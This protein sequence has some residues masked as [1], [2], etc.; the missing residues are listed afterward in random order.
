MRQL[1]SRPFL[2]QGRETQTFLRGTRPYD[3][4]LTN[5]PATTL[6]EVCRTYEAQFSAFNAETSPD[7]LTMIDNAQS[8]GAK[9][10]EA[11]K[12]LKKS[13]KT[14]VNSFEDFAMN[15]WTML[16][17]LQDFETVC[18]AEYFGKSYRPLLNHTKREEF[19]NPFDVLLT[20]ADHEMQDV[21]A[22]LEAIGTRASIKAVREKL[23][24]KLD[25][26]QKSIAKLQAGKKTFK[27]FFTSKPSTQVVAE[28]EAEAKQ[29][30]EEIYKVE[31]LLRIITVRMG[32]AEIPDYNDRRLRKYQHMIRFFARSG[33]QE[34]NEISRVARGI[35]LSEDCQ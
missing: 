35:Y 13:I 27:S 1:L 33:V 21:E 29:T 23:H 8:F 12:K 26:H 28:I 25:S 2:Y 9:H 11:L 34:F 18:V 5:M 7:L 16:D 14:V 22:L 30:E 15:Y 3:I 19:I 10:I 32:K 24:S 6:A 20:G 4:E 17:S 31:G